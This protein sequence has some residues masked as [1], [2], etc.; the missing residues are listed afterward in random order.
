[1]NEMEFQQIQ[2]NHIIVILYSQMD[3]HDPCHL[4]DDIMVL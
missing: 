4:V 1:M 2:K 3:K